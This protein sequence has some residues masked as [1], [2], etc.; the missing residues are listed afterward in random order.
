MKNTKDIFRS[1][2]SRNP[3]DV[4]SFIVLEATQ[5]IDNYSYRIEENKKK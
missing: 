1:F 5:N 4:K 2:Q 3:E